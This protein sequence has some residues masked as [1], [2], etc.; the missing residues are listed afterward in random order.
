MLGQEPRWGSQGGE[1]FGYRG[2]GQVKG[3]TVKGV[4]SRAKGLL[5]QLPHSRSAFT[6]R[7]LEPNRAMLTEQSM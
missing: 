7:Y 6:A 5:P 1:A 4:G 2:I 3:C